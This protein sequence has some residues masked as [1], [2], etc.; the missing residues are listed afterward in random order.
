MHSQ[1]FVFGCGC[2]H[3]GMVKTFIRLCFFLV[4]LGSFS[5]TSCLGDTTV[6]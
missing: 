2:M 5:F 4:L 1:R 3:E 6:K